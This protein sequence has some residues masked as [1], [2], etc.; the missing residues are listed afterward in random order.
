MKKRK[1]VAVTFLLR[2]PGELKI[3]EI[4]AHIKNTL[5]EVEEKFP[6]PYH[7]TLHHN[8]VEVFDAR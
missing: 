8:R 3:D 1:T 2:I 7:I 5:H 4:T 6:A